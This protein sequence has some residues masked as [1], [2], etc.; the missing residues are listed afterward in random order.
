MPYKGMVCAS[1]DRRALQS[2]SS[3]DKGRGR[4]SRQASILGRCKGTI[5]CQSWTEDRAPAKAPRQAGRCL[6]NTLPVW[7]LSAGEVFV[8][9]C[10]RAC[11]HRVFNTC[12]CPIGHPSAT[13]TSTLS[14]SA[15]S[16]RKP[17]VIPSGVQSLHL[18]C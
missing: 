13:S 6:F 14:I 7:S 1:A 2:S 11:E 3:A 17:S 5:W 8:T 10:T 18:L 9:S 15:P 4:R 16:S 12:S